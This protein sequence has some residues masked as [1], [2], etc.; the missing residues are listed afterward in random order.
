[1]QTTSD[2]RHGRVGGKIKRDD[3]ILKNKLEKRAVRV[4]GCFAMLRTFHGDHALLAS[5][6]HSTTS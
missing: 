6:M 4:A 5:E 3:S 1:M 2:I